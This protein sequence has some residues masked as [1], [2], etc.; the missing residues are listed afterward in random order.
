[1]R[2]F[3]LLEIL[4]V[5]LLTAMLGGIALPR[6]VS[7]YDSVR[8]ASERDELLDQLAGLGQI[9]VSA[10]EPLQILEAED[11][12][13]AGLGPPETWRVTVLEPFV[14]R[15]N[16]SCTEGRLSLAGRGRVATVR[17]VPPFCRP[18]VVNDGV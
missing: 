17:L 2:G 7:I 3:T 13:R 18:E 9:R 11:L 8:F 15:A 5:L 16:G 10:G 4:V 6:V 14:L 12:R 1:M